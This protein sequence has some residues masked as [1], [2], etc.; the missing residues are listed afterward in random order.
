MTVIWVPTDTHSGKTS[1]SN[2][3][4]AISDAKSIGAEYVFL[5]GDVTDNSTDAQWDNIWNL[6]NNGEIPANRWYML[7][8]NHDVDYGKTLAEV[9]VQMQR[10]NPTADYYLGTLN[11]RAYGVF[12][13]NLLFL[14]MSDIGS[15]DGYPL[16]Q[17]DWTDEMMSWWKDAVKQ[18]YNK[19]NVITCT[20]QHVYDTNKGS[21]ASDTF[22]SYINRD[23]EQ[24]DE[25]VNW[26]QQY[27]IVAWLNGHTHGSS[28]DP[29]GIATKYNC[30]FVDCDSIA[31]WNG[32]YNPTDSKFLMVN[33]SDTE[34]QVKHYNHETNEWESDYS[35]TIPLKFP[36]DPTWTPSVPPPPHEIPCIDFGK[37]KGFRR[38]ILPDKRWG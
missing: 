16:C 21:T 36:F 33:S 12:I 13:G 30:V 3:S 20:H 34:I 6:I 18:Y 8:G 27:P 23:H 17:G 2:I 5:L 7:A 25:I 31:T 10:G 29:N 11:S 37:C 15:A 38:W 28:R 1:N 26:I 19:C 22:I 35:G 32:T 9:E 4:D 14:M 24:S